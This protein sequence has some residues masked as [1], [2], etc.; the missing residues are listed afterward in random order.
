MAASFPTGQGYTAAQWEAYLTANTNPANPDYTGTAT[1]K[2]GTPLKGKTWAQVYAAFYAENTG[3]TPDE[4]AVDVEELG[5]E[6]ALAVGTSAA[7]TGAVNATEASGEGISTASI[8]PSWLS[9]LPAFAGFL[10]GLGE[11]STWIRVGKVV[12]GGTLVVIGLAHI[13]GADNAIANVA[14]SVPIIPV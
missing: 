14:R 5:F 1:L 6:E 3:Q 12:I 8:L 11:A 4:I 10:N 9:G 2:N 7:V 13:T